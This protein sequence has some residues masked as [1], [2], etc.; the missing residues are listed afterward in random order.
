MKYL[1]VKVYKVWK[2]FS[3]G[4]RTKKHTEK[5]S[6]SGKMLKIGEPR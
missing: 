2:Q 1:G 5:L 3:D 6:R 4:S